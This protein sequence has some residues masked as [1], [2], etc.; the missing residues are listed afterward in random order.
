ELENAAPFAPLRARLKT[1]FDSSERIPHV[2]KHGAFYYN[3]WRDAEHVRGIWRR[4]TAA[5][6]ALAQPDWDTVI[7][8]DRLAADEDENWVWGGA[9]CLYPDAERCLVSLSR[10]GGDAHVVREYDIGARA[11]VADGFI[12]AEAKGGASW[13]DRDTVFVSSDFGP[14]SMTASGYPRIVKQWRRGTPLVDALTLFEAGADDLSVDAYKDF[15][16]GNEHQFIERQIDFYSSE[17][18]LREGAALRRVAKPDDATAYTV[19]EHLLIELRSDWTVAGASYPQGALLATDFADFMRGGR[20]FDLLFAP[21]AT[22]SL[23]GVSAT[24]SAL[25]LNV[26]DKVKNR[27]VELRHA[28]GAWQRR[29]VAAPAF[30][31]L[32]ASPVDAYESEQ[33]FL[34]VNDFLTPTTL[35]MGE[36]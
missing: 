18:F 8:L 5:S 9:S 35:Y 7:D 6:F 21:T 34:T 11:F 14:G 22:S 17:L 2:G 12:L 30:G 24:R 19:R 4:T 33:Y 13:I 16:P 3:F 36:A 23:D 28:D 15:T 26:L 29:D 27:L 1:I 31:T 32:D 10:G 20:R 25:L